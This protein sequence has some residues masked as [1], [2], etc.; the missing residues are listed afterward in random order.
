LSQHFG[1]YHPGA[2]SLRLRLLPAD[3]MP[4]PA[5]PA[6]ILA[7]RRPHW[8]GVHQPAPEVRDFSLGRFH[9]STVLSPGGRF[10]ILKAG[11]GGGCPPRM[12][13]GTRPFVGLFFG[14]RLRQAI[15]LLN[16]ADQLI[17]LAGD[18]RPVIIG[19]LSPALASR[20]GE[21]LP[22]SFDLVPIHVQS[23][24]PGFHWLDLSRGTFTAVPISRG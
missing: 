3:S 13:L 12:F 5:R 11:C 20:A 19:E 14:L 15:P 6:L 16:A 1:P 10:L 8:L 17:L 9:R 2:R 24:V 7:M 18:R 21:L 22:F 23:L 4:P